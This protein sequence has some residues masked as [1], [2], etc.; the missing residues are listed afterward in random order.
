MTDDRR[1]VQLYNEED[2]AIINFIEYRRLLVKGSLYALLQPEDDLELLVPFRVEDRKDGDEEIYVYI[3][4]DH[5]IE[6]VEEAWQRLH[7]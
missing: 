7:S 5:E 6:A 3:V 2:K 4:D 1:L